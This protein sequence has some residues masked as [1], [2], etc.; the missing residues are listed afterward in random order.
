MKGHRLLKLAASDWC[1]QVIK[2]FYTAKQL[3]LKKTS[4]LLWKSIEFL[5]KAV[6]LVTWKWS[7][8]VQGI[9]VT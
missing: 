5:T 7:C 1:M 4:M 3:I 8:P 2:L 6:P 9:K